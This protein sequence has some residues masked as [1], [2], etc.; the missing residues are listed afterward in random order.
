MFSDSEGC[1]SIFSL[2]LFLVFLTLKSTKVKYIK[3]ISSGKLFV[4]IGLC[5]LS[6]K[7]IFF[8]GRLRVLGHYKRIKF[9]TIVKKV[10]ERQMVL[11]S[12]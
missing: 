12:C 2:D 9:L 6:F 5:F 10:N 4:L 3:N 1:T 11:G 8:I 7:F